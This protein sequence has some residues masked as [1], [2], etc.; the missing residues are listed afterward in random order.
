MT[1]RR[2]PP[3]A[4]PN[5]HLVGAVGRVVDDGATSGT[6]RVRVGGE[7]WRARSVDGASLP[8]GTEVEVNAVEGLVL[9]VRRRAST[10]P[11]DASADHAQRAEQAGG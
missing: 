2:T 5:A 4:Q 7:T 6:L 11:Q 9:D 8:V 1:Q 3:P 10:E